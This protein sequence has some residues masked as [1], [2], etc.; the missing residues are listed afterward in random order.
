[1]ADGPGI[2][3]VM[4]DLHEKKEFKVRDFIVIRWHGGNLV[5]SPYF[6][7]SGGMVVDFV[8]LAMVGEHTMTVSV[9][10]QKVRDFGGK[11]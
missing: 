7:H 3:D 4:F 5:A 6:A 10:A 9:D 1:M 8:E 11:K 2:D